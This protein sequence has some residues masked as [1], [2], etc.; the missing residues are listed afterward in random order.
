M[1]ENTDE[2]SFEYGHF[3]RRRQQKRRKKGKGINGVRTPFWHFDYYDVEIRPCVCFST[4][5]VQITLMLTWL[6]ENQLTSS[7]GS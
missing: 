7:V 1:R 4:R 5:S 2:K 6:T 3:S